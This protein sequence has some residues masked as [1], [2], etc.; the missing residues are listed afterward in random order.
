[1]TDIRRQILPGDLVVHEYDRPSVQCIRLVVAVEVDGI[2]TR[3][4]TVEYGPCLEDPVLAFPDML[5]RIELFGIRV[6]CSLQDETLTLS[7]TGT[8]SVATYRDGEPRR[9]QQHLPMSLQPKKECFARWLN[10]LRK[11]AA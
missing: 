8:A 1:M 3:Y 11:S 9:W 2:W 6:E 7:E 5:T 10:F 4:M